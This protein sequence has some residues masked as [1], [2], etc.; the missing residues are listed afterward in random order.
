[1]SIKDKTRWVLAQECARLIIEEGVQN[2]RSARRKAA[3]RLG[4]RLNANLPSDVEI[5]AALIEYHRIY[6]PHRQS[7]HIYRLRQLAMELMQFLAEFSP[8]LVGGVWDGSAGPY[9][10]ITLHIFA[11][12]P[13]DVIVKL[14][15]SNIPYS[16]S[17]FRMDPAGPGFPALTFCV[18]GVPVELLLLSHEWKRKARVAPGGDVA[19]LKAMMNDHRST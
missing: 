4:T 1:M 9:C 12:T 16:E 2:F 6:R 10:V 13:E 14:L 18:D 3:H 8:R 19:A 7:A 5:E 11:P 17:D 15:N